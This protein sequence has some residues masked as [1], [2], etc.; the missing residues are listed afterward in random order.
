MKS[1]RRTVTL[2]LVML[3][4]ATSSLT[5]QKTNA[6]LTELSLEELMGEDIFPMNVMGSHIH[7]KGEWMIGYRYMPMKMTEFMD[8]KEHISPDRI[9]D[10]YM[11]TPTSMTMDMHMFEVM[12][13][14]SDDL[15]VMLMLPYKSMSMTSKTKI[16]AQFSTQSKGVGD[17]QLMAH[18]SFFWHDPH[19]LILMMSAGLPTGSID[20]RGDTPLG[21]SQ[22]LPYPMQ[23]GYGTVSVSP[24]LTYLGQSEKWIWG[25]HVMAKMGLGENANEYRL[26]NKYHLMGILTRKITEWLSLT[27]RI[28]GHIGDNISGA[29]AELNAAMSPPSDPQNH[30]GTMA[31]FQ[32]SFDLYL[33][34][35]ALG[36]SRFSIETGVPFYHDLDGPQMDEHQSFILVYTYTF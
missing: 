28:D 15:T 32:F 35:G 24:G 27:T 29:D 18:Y 26:G 9:L 19:R 21:D 8:G 2:F 22:R 7:A 20:N 16:G 23:S 25:G 10:S 3:L 11:M 36:G 34:G 1:G 12:Y 6:D 17:I 14:L 30:G 33:P 5:G 31:H 4:F 13:G